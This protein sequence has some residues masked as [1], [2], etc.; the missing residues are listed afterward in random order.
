MLMFS[1]TSIAYVFYLLTNRFLAPNHKDIA[2]LDLTTVQQLMRNQLSDTN[3]I[4]VSLAGDI[5]IPEMEK[6]VL[7]YLGTVPPPSIASSKVEESRASSATAAAVITE[8]R[9]SG[10]S[11]KDENDAE[12]YNVSINDNIHCSDYLFNLFVENKE[13]RIHSSTYTW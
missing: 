10:G 4:E 13:T 6:L 5:S 2:A 8:D 9:R 11:S 3:K 7:T 1:I 12:M